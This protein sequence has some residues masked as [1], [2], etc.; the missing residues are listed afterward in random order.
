[1][2][3]IIVL[4]DG[5]SVEQ[6]THRQLAAQ[7]GLYYRLYLTQFAG[8]WQVGA[9]AEAGSMHSLLRRSEIQHGR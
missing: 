9:V 1:M 6:E 3:L 5:R 4:D 8:Q 2:S 7:R